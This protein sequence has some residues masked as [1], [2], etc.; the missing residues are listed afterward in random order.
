M[1]ASRVHRLLHDDLDAG[2]ELLVRENIA[3]LLTFTRRICRDGAED[4][5][6]EA[7]LKAYRALRSIDAETLAALDLRPWLYTIA[8]NTAYS[9]LRSAKRRPASAGAGS[10]AETL[11]APTEGERLDSELKAAL[12][13]LPTL[14]RDAVVLRHVLDMSSRD[15]A[16]ILECSENTLKSHVARGLSA[17]R[18]DLKGTNP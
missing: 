16:A 5:T 4:V 15:V 7:L 12:D 2:F 1:G 3:G 14:Q 9:A 6:Q 11:R 17:L 10:V 13:R 8:R 18:T